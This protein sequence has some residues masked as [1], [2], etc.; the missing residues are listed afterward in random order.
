MN[1]KNLTLFFVLSLILMGCGSEQD[2]TRAAVRG[3]VKLDGDPLPE[4][5]IRFIPAEDNKGPQASITIHNG[6]F[7]I[8]KDFGPL[9]GTNRIEIIST[10]DG[11]FAPDD[12]QAIEKIKAAGI[13]RIKVVKVPPQY[14]RRSTLSKSVTSE[15]ENDFVFELI[16]TPADKSN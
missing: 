6:I 8:G 10:D 1:S 14:N 9:V 13:K 5:V 2:F 12:E 3:I 11:G 16:S 15:G 7:S 4:G